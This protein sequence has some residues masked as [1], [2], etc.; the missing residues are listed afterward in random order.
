MRQAV[1]RR[2]AHPPLAVMVFVVVAAWLVPWDPV[3]G[4]P[5]PSISP[6]SVFTV[7]QIDRAEDYARWARVWSWS[8]LAVSLAV[9]GWLAFSGRW[10]RL[11]RTSC[12]W[13]C[14]GS[15]CRRRRR[16]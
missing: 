10:R 2:T 9:A 15:W 16:L 7:Q 12:R 14:R 11:L 6:E 1:P 5:L 3:P 13:W 8:G 4:G